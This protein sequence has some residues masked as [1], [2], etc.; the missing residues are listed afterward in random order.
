MFKFDDLLREVG[1]FGRYQI[2]KYVIFV[3]GNIP[4]GWHTLSII[5]AG[6]KQ[7]YWCKIPEL[8][9]FS[10]ADQKA[11]GI[12]REM[13]LSG[14][15]FNSKCRRFDL[16]FTEITEYQLRHWNESEIVGNTTKTIGCSS[17]TFDQ[18]EYISTIYSQFGLT[19]DR[20]WLVPM[21]QTV[22]MFG[23]LLG[24][25]ILG[26][27][28]DRFGR[29]IAYFLT[30]TG[31]VVMGSIQAFV[32]NIYLYI[33]TKLLLGASGG[34]Y[35]AVGLVLIL[36]VTG[37]KQRVFVSVIYHIG[38][39]T[40]MFFLP[41][42]A[43]FVR[44]AYHLQMILGVVP[45]ILL[46]TFFFIDESPRW[47]LQKHR[48]DEAELLLA[49]IAETNGKKLHDYGQ[50]VTEIKQATRDVERAQDLAAKVG[51]QPT[52]ID[53]MKMPN[54]RKI[55]CI[56]FLQW[57]TCAGS[58]Y[59][60]MLMPTNL[61]TNAYIGV[62]LAGAAVPVAFAIVIPVII[63]LGRRV[64]MGGTLITL[65]TLLAVSAVVMNF[66]VLTPLV[67]VLI[68][69]CRVCVQGAFCTIYLFTVELFPTVVRNIGVGTGSSLARVGGLLA[70]Q[71]AF[72]VSIWRPL[73][74]LILAA[75][76]IVT[77]ALNYFLPET[78]NRKLPET[79]EDGEKFGRKRKKRDTDNADIKMNGREEEME[80]FK[81]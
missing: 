8:G 15:F 12:P 11:I 57:F 61:G 81:E 23:W 25:T 36:E 10:S 6:G 73:P 32:P 17:W 80:A 26:W 48:F 55:S 31:V 28:S 72:L 38:F 49:K 5:F 35:F 70:P 20:S 42:I 39:D 58:F 40:A 56:N 37:Q 16:N 29:R 77:G 19:C 7:D 44:D 41:L 13:T 46:P 67:V 14:E 54:L 78:L 64:S 76:A 65:G 68:F 66:Q 51:H 4:V 69:M 63:K 62:A 24:T 18:S 43:W 53:I 27:I 34:A 30:Y 75:F 3:F 33:V 74:V 47:L 21:T 2:L 60:L 59:G 45:A 1:Q 50:L 71:L 79:L 52:L 22:Y 9:N